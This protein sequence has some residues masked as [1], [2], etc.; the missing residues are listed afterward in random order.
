LRRQQFERAQKRL[1]MTRGDFSRRLKNQMP[2]RK[3]C[4][5]ADIII[6]NSRGLRQ[7]QAQVDAIIDRLQKRKS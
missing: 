6:D 4:D 1:G 7:T 5:M 3:K 2:L